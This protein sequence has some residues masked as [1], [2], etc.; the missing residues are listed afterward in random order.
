MHSLAQRFCIGLTLILVGCSKS[1]QPTFIPLVSSPVITGRTP[2][3]DALIWVETDPVHRFAALVADTHSMEPFFTSK[4][5]PLCIRY[6]GQELPN[7]TVAI[8]NHDPA[9]QHV[10]HVIADQNADSFYFSGY[11]NRTS[12]GWFKKSTCEGFVVGQLYLP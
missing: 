5:L 2:V 11:N 6:A 8:Y 7:G 12:D 3:E 10:I 9:H 1:P 4:S